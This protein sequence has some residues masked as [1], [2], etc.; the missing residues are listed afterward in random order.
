M[1]WICPAAHGK[2]P[3]VLP[4]REKTA[5]GHRIR[6][7]AGCWYTIIRRYI[8]LE[9]GLFRL[10]LEEGADLVAR[11]RAHHALIRHPLSWITRRGPSKGMKAVPALGSFLKINS[12]PSSGGTSAITSRDRPAAQQAQAPV[13]ASHSCSCRS[14]RDQL[15]A[16]V[17]MDLAV[18]L[19]RDAARR[20]HGG[21]PLRSTPSFFSTARVNSPPWI[22]AMNSAKAGPYFR[23]GR[24]G[25]G[26]ATKG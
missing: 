9:P 8:R 24:E 10:A 15:G 19:R 12:V 23:V 11:C 4:E 21:R 18:A 1:C 20:H 22:A 3:L 14:T 7:L 13:F 16:A 25:A 2:V 17:G 6:D 26:W 5:A